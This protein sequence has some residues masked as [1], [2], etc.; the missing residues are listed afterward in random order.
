MQAFRLMYDNKMLPRYSFDIV[1]PEQ[2][3]SM[4]RFWQVN[5]FCV[6]SLPVNS[7]IGFK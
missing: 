1:P 6:Q 7:V 2:A 3:E 5:W 4:Q